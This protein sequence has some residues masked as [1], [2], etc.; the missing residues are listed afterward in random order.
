MKCTTLTVLWG[1][2]LLLPAAA[3]AD[4]ELTDKATGAV[5][6]L[7]T[8]DDGTAVLASKVD[9]EMDSYT[10]QPKCYAEHPIYGLGA[11]QAVKGGWRIMMGSSQIVSFDGAPPLD[12]P[13][14]VPQ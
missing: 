11:W 4:G 12:N 10:L 7:T 14:C 1:I 5:Y 6:V 13:A 9:G 3:F 2:A 8:K